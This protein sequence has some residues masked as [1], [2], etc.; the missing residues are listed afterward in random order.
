MKSIQI[1]VIWADMI[2][3]AFGQALLFVIAWGILA[4]ALYIPIRRRRRWR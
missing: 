4:L 1:A 3:C 2:L